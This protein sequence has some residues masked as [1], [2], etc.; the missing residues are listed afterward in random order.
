ML[1][2]EKVKKEM[3]VKF[4]K[5]KQGNVG[6]TLQDK[7]GGH[8][9]EILQDKK[10]EESVNEM[11]QNIKRRK[12]WWAAKNHTAQSM[13]ATVLRQFTST[14]ECEYKH[15]HKLFPLSLQTLLFKHQ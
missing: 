1:H 7:K 3:V 5:I 11:W 15:G 4:Y 6:E 13:M 14:E 8:T 10:K 2:D 12:C 9:G